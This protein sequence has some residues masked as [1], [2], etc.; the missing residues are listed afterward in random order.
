MDRFVSYTYCLFSFSAKRLISFIRSFF[1]PIF[2]TLLVASQSDFVFN[3][4]RWNDVPRT[5][6]VFFF[7]LSQ[8]ATF[9]QF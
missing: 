8:I 6:R 9:S 4:L 7:F 2:S 3:L 5:S 1:S